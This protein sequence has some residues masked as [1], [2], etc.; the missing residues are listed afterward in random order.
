V[1]APIYLGTGVR[2]SFAVVDGLGPLGRTLG[3][4][5]RWTEAVKAEVERNRTVCFEL[6][7]VLLAPW[8]RAPVRLEERFAVEALRVRDSLARAG[9]PPLMHLGEAESIVA[10]LHH[11]ELTGDRDHPLA[12]FASDD[13]SARRRARRDGLE[14][15]DTEDLLKMCSVPL[16]SAARRH[17][18]STAGCWRSGA[19]STAGRPATGSAA[20]RTS[21]DEADS[22]DRRGDRAASRYGG[23]RSRAQGPVLGGPGSAFSQ[24]VQ[25]LL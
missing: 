24:A 18:G 4:R 7:N 25:G 17:S 20:R 9:D 12:A 6:W 2:W 21:W 19:R 16:A 8:L 10:A 1:A 3:R 22:A 23:Q 14:V 5:A 13:Y 15:L 11:G